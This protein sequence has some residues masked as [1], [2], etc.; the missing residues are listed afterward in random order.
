M[1]HGPL[2]RPG[3]FESDAGQPPA[4]RK[5]VNLYPLVGRKRSSAQREAAIRKM[6]GR[7]PR[8]SPVKAAMLRRATVEMLVRWEERHGL[9]WTHAVDHSWK[10]ALAVRTPSVAR[11]VYSRALALLPR[12]LAPLSVY[13][14]L[15]RH[16]SGMIHLH[17]LWCA[18][19]AAGV[20]GWWRAVKETFGKHW[21]WARVWPISPTPTVQARTEATAYMFK[22]ATKANPTTFAQLC[23][24][25]NLAWNGK[26]E[27]TVR[28]GHNRSWWVTMRTGDGLLVTEREV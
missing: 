16:Q 15:E 8:Y 19:Q 10:A 4:R 20:G 14:V 11:K 26:G 21:G 9:L 2:Y 23:T 3:Q 18:P 28:W 6:V 1:R 12:L 5:P 25:Y 24:W 22:H 13:A 7:P 17:T 27:V